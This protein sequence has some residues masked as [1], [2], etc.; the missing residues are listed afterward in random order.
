MK[1]MNKSLTAAVCAIPLLAGSALAQTRAVLIQNLDESIRA[2]YQE[3]AFVNCNTFQCTLFFPA[4]PAG[5]RR[6]VEQVSCSIF[7]P[8]GTA[9][10]RMQSLE[11]SFQD[12]RPVRAYLP[13][14]ANPGSS[15]LF[16]SNAAT[17]LFFNAGDAPRVD[18]SSVA[19]AIASMSCTLSGREIAVP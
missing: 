15:I 3:A 12:R 17:L 6:T 9:E 2:P 7:L 5:R 13:Y 11:L 14:A 4:V 19:G 1:T 8:S 18:A 16:T 10:G